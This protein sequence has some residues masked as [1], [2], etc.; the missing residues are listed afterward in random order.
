MMKKIILGIAGACA[1]AGLATTASAQMY[2]DTANV[3]SATAIFDRGNIP[4]ECRV[5]PTNGPQRAYPKG[6][7]T[8]ANE[9][10]VESVPSERDV[11]RCDN[12]GTPT[13]R[14]VGYE[15]TYEYNGH[16]F[17]IRMPYD[18]GPQMPV[19]VEVRPPLPRDGNPAPR[20]PN[21]RGPY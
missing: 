13:G 5:E 4:R 3:L 14:I 16:Q 2:G 21:Y 10:L 6:Y 8:A 1:L 11:G 9:V 19:N 15:V 12:T 7:R 17:I 20:T 18:P